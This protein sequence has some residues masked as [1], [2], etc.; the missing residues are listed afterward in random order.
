MN[1]WY[2]NLGVAELRFDLAYYR[3]IQ[4]TKRIYRKASEEITALVNIQKNQ[5]QY[6]DERIYKEHICSY[7]YCWLISNSEDEGLS[8]EDNNRN[9]EVI[10]KEARIE[11]NEY[12]YK[13][14]EER[15]KRYFESLN[16]ENEEE[17]NEEAIWE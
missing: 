2:E 9:R 11:Y 7:H 15:E 6:P 17:S 8:N 3:Q 4:E 16:R 14:V 10:L 1:R 12:I 13:E 5:P